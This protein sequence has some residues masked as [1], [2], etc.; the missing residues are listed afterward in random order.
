MFL[1]IHGFAFSD[2]YFLESLLFGACS[3]NSVLTLAKNKSKA[4]LAEI[5]SKDDII[6]VVFKFIMIEKPIISFKDSITVN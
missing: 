4:K 5:L 3:S 2:I 6:Q 1:F